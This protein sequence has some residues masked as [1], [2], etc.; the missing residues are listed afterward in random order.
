MY[1]ENYDFYKII[2][3]IGI[4]TL[5]WNFVLTKY[6]YWINAAIFQTSIDISI[7]IFP[8]SAYFLKLFVPN[9]S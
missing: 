1:V 7:L 8:C 9:S 3:S 4:S 5:K 2:V 6:K